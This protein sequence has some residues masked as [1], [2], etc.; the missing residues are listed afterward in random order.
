[1]LK[2]GIVKRRKAKKENGLF[3]TDFIRQGDLVWATHPSD[4]NLQV[5]L[6]LDDAMR[7]PKREREVF[8]NYCYQVDL[9]LFSGYLRPRDVGTDDSNYMNHS[10]DPNC[11]YEGNALVARRDILPGEEI[12]YDYCT[13]T[14]ARDWGFACS[15]GAPC[16][17]GTVR[18]DDWMGLLHVYES[19]FIE[20]MN[21]HF[22][23]RYRVATKTG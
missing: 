5:Y 18:R 14:T 19:H 12:T 1:M 15:C 11:W 6:S 22:C 21:R 3:A 16:C 23:S 9:D 4:S 17:R 2:P 13:D 7:L 8:F 20:Y 10:C